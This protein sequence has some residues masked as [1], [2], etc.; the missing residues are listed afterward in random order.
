MPRDAY[1]SVNDSLAIARNEL[2]FKATRASGP[3][4]QHVNRSAT[5]VELFWNVAGSTGLTEEMR[6]RITSR[7]ASR[8]DR[9]GRIRVVASERRSQVQNRE[10]A[11]AKL[12]EIIRSALRVRRPRR[13]TRP[14]RA[15]AEQRLEAK[16]LRA[17]RKR[18]RRWRD[19]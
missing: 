6:E 5:R 17:T 1:L 11:E 12:V 8:M 7:L 10:A 19:D 16:R 18:D 4:G 2:E 3:G 15:S 14:T 13:A 9:E